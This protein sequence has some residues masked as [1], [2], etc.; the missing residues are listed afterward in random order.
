MLRGTLFVY[1]HVTL[2]KLSPFTYAMVDEQALRCSWCVTSA[3]KRL[4]CVTGEVAFNYDRLGTCST[5]PTT[6]ALL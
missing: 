2:I 4:H 1:A 5:Q 6:A 3:F